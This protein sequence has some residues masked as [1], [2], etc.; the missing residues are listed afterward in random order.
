MR[1]AIIVKNM[2]T[3]IT[4]TDYTE[5]DPAKVRATLEQRVEQLSVSPVWREYYAWRVQ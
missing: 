2:A 5:T 4:I 3:G 1:T